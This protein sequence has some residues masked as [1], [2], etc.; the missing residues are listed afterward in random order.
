[1]RSKFKFYILLFFLIIIIGIY[2]KI[3]NLQSPEKFF[4]DLNDEELRTL[5]ATAGQT[6]SIDNRIKIQ[7]CKVNGPLPDHLCTPGAIFPNATSGVICVSGYTKIVRSVSTSLRKK[8]YQEYNIAY[9][10]P[11][12]SYEVDHLIPLELGGSNDIA[13]LFPESALPTPGFKEKDLVEN[14]LHNEVCARRIDLSSAQ[15]QIANNWLAVYQ[16]LTPKQISDLKSQ[17][18]SWA[19]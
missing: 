8:V 4:S 5:L 18:I 6:F 13:N 17:Y 9:P 19:N 16:I 1:M 3:S 10:P 11:T 7:D 14:Y 2:G 15:K 12:G